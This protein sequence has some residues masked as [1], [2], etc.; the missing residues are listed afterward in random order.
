[1][2]TNLD[3]N[4]KLNLLMVLFISYKYL[5]LKFEYLFNKSLIFFLFCNNNYSRIF[6]NWKI[7]NYNKVPVHPQ[8]GCHTE[9]K[10][11]NNNKK[12]KEYYYKKK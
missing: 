2:F 3:Y 11:K 6:K 12:K 10:W 4:L 7:N 1:M 8:G 5:S 9:Q